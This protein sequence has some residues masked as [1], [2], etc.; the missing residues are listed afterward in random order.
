VAS[1]IAWRGVLYFRTFFQTKV[2]VLYFL[3]A[4]QRR[5]SP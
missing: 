5:L 1:A 3:Y 2:R 4:I